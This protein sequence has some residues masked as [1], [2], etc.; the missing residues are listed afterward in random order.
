MVTLGWVAF[1]DNYGSGNE[2]PAQIA[3]IVLGCEWE[4]L[5]KQIP[6]D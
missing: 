5:A 3:A 1:D 2:A 4:L 6:L